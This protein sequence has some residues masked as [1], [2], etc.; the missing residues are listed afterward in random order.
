MSAARLQASLIEFRLRQ[1]IARP[2]YVVG[3]QEVRP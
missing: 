3:S 2:M 1:N